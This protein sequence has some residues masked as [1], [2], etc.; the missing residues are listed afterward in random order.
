VETRRGGE[1]RHSR[2]G[3]NEKGVEEDRECGEGKSLRVHAFVYTCP[4]SFLKLNFSWGKQR[5]TSMSSA[6]PVSRV[7]QITAASL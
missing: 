2:H 1:E 4:T 3:I 6:W 5:S 7:T